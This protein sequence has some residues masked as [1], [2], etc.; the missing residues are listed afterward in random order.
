[1][2]DNLLAFAIER[3][4]DRLRRRAEKD[5]PRKTATRKLRLPG[6]LSD[7][8]R[9]SAEGTELFLVE[10]DSAGGSAKQ[11]RDR[12]TQA[13]LPL[14]GKILK[15]RGVLVEKTAPLEM[16]D[17]LVPVLEIEQGK[18]LE[19]SMFRIEKRPRAAIAGQSA[20]RSF[21]ELK[22]QYARSLIPANNPL[23]RE[24][25]TPIRPANPVIASIPAGFRAVSI[26][27]DS[28]SSVEGW[29]TAGALVDVQWISDMNGKKAANI[30][31]QNAKV[32][33][34]E[35]QVEAQGAQAQAQGPVPTTV[36]LLVNERD[37][38]KISLASLTGTMMLH[39]RGA[40]DI[41]KSSNVD[42]PIT[43]QDLNG[44]SMNGR[45]GIQG[46]LKMKNSDGTIR[47]IG[48]KDGRIE[49]LK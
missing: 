10:G 4:E 23:N 45:D 40:T 5:T 36:T 11:A 16:I 34:A 17:V 6:K 12:E 43:L 20:I 18:K 41:G 33:S 28:I 27:V 9:E 22:N 47:E 39:L 19:P 26:R 44:S 38:Q 8:A 48:I 46:V 2:A 42:G 15:E 37:A 13:V 3:A 29:A 30:I 25:M 21:E 35:R 7:C 14:R 31:V 49:D 1:M 32:L 24:V